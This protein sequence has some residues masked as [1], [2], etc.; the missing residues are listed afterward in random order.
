MPRVSEQL[1]RCNHEIALS[2]A[3]TAQHEAEKKLEDFKALVLDWSKELWD[4]ATTDG[5]NDLYWVE[6]IS[7]E[8]RKAVE[9]NA[10]T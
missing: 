5:R 10:R 7:K 3:H 6:E 1:K 4:A 8:M 9:Q 2:R